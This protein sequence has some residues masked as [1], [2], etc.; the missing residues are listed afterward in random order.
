MSANKLQL[1]EEAERRGILP[2]EQKAMLDEARK[3]GLVQPLSAQPAGQRGGMVEQGTISREDYMRERGGV[4]FGGRPVPQDVGVSDPI[5]QPNRMTD[6]LQ[7]IAG[8]YRAPASGSLLGMT[9]QKP[10]FSAE[11]N[12]DAPQTVGVPEKMSRAQSA[13][14]GVNDFNPVRLATGDRGYEAALTQSVKDN[15]V[16]TRLGQAASLTAG[17]GAQLTNRAIIA[18]PRL[19]PSAIAGRT[20]GK[21]VAA[22]LTRYGGRLATLGALGAADYA[23]YNFAAEAP[24]QARESG[25]PMPTMGERANFAAEGL[26]DPYGYAPLPAMSMLYRA[27]RG[28]FTAGKNTTQATLAANKSAPKPEV[29]AAGVPG[30]PQVQWRG[31]SFTPTDVQTRVAMGGIDPKTNAS[32]REI[33]IDRLLK[34]G[35]DP[36]EAEKAVRILSYNGYSNV[37][38]MLFEIDNNL[39]ELA[40][41]VGRVNRP[42]QKVLRDEFQARR[43][44]MPDEI[45][46][47]L[48][49]AVG[50]S[51][52]DLETFASNMTK[53][54]EGASSSGYKAAYGVEVSD[55]AWQKILGLLRET[56]DG[57]DAARKGAVLARN[58]A[59]RDPAK[60]E[61]ARQLDELADV[62]GGG[63]LPNGK[64]STMALDF[65]D[66]GI[67]R[68][69]STATR[70]GDNAYSSSLLDFRGALRGSGL[71]AET[72]L[73]IPRTIYAQYK[74]AERAVEFGEK[75]FGKS[76]SLRDMKNQFSAAM[77]QADEAFE[78]GIGEGSGIIDQALMMGWVRGAENAVEMADNPQTLIRQLYGSERQRDKLLSMLRELPDEAPSG[79]KSDVT[80][81]KKALVGSKGVDQDYRFDFALSTGERVKGRTTMRNLFDRQKAMI[82]SER[83]T[84]GGSPT[85]G[86]ADAIANQG[87]DTR[88][89]LGVL[90]LLKAPQEIPWKAASA[91]I[92]RITQP[93]IYNPAISRELG[94]LLATRGKD[95][96]LAVIAEIRARQIATGK[97]PKPPSG[98]VPPSGPIRAGGFAGF[99]GKKPP[100]AEPLTNEQLFSEY[101]RL[102]PRIVQ[103]SKTL[104]GVDFDSVPGAREAL[105]ETIGK[106]GASG[107]RASDEQIIEETWNLMRRRMRHGPDWPP[108]KSSLQAVGPDEYVPDLAR[109]VSNKTFFEVDLDTAI[110][111]SLTDLDDILAMKGMRRDGDLI[112]LDQVKALMEDP[113]LRAL[114][115]GGTRPNSLSP[116]IRGDLSN[117]LAGA[118]L[119]GIAPADSAEE[120]ARNMAIGAGLGGG[121]R[122]VGKAFGSEADGA[123]RS[124]GARSAPPKTAAQAAKFETPGSPEWE[125]AKAKGLDMS[126]EGT[127]ARARQQGYNTD[128][129]LYHGTDR[130]GFE[131]FDVNAPARARSDGEQ[132]IF[133]TNNP[134]KASSF[135]GV[136]NQSIMPLYVRGKIKTVSADDLP[137]LAIPDGSGQM[138]YRSEAFSDILR[139]AKAEGFDG[140]RFRNVNEGAVGDQIAIFDP[141]NI[142]SVNAAFD[143]DKAASPILTA[144]FGSGR[145]VGKPKPMPMPPKRNKIGTHAADAAA[146]AAIGM[147]PSTAQADTGGVSAE[148]DAAK[149]RVTDIEAQIT[150]IEQQAIPEL[151][152]QIRQLQDPKGDIASKQEILKLRGRSLGTTG[153]RGDGVDGV[154]GRNTLAAINDEVKK[155]EADIRL[156][157][158]DKDDLAKELDKARKRRT[159]IEL[160]QVAEDGKV[161]PLT[162]SIREFAPWIGTGLGLAW[163]TRGRYGAVVK[164]RA[165]AQAAAQRAN[166]LVNT[167]PKVSRAQSGPNSLSERASNLNEFWRLGGAGE[168]V[169]FKKSKAGKWSQR[170]KPA[171]P[172]TLFPKEKIPYRAVDAAWVGGGLTEAGISHSFVNDYKA[173]VEKARADVERY[174]EA[175]DVANAKLATEELKKAENM[176]AI[177]MAARALGLA[178]A[179]GRLAA[180]GKMPYEQVRPHINMSAAEQEQAR[181]L[182]KMK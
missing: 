114:D 90:N 127:K 73:N 164:S 41:A 81:K 9:P 30:V 182:S 99:G 139:Q 39:A 92:E 122:R 136:K 115:T 7:G 19:V 3:R 105:V 47:A 83:M 120:R 110:R 111:E 56:P 67:G 55:D 88:R 123:V 43:E 140:V 16:T 116:A 78:D 166:S 157:R 27:G 158:Q 101:E 181:L 173:R 129:V 132:A 100:K 6:T 54:A 97:G 25:A 61:A 137:E 138:A 34:E 38:E 94:E 1:L 169:P 118:G 23:A 177:A 121:A 68:K 21:S 131:K 82:E 156:R 58:S 66:R 63:G 96:L 102:A 69:V 162:E 160:R 64:L 86:A 150:S 17:G 175:G 72:G 179:G 133:L 79:I 14:L 52:D 85:A 53:A 60:L 4:G 89:A 155:I 62:L 153:P 130:A 142:R 98:T 46:I 11:L 22:R 45:R 76:R 12:L 24:N 80:K 91:V 44:A 112:P 26:S 171:E 134:T 49:E 126:Q 35:F 36:D 148:L 29:M 109:M 113:R 168:N 37:D 159:D 135:A 57:V 170:P 10:D 28:A 161:G 65:L 42:G 119:G 74:A 84:V 143:P 50:A 117:A 48:R 176:L 180:G 5:P 2:P 87:G 154:E 144:G 40:T 70:A 124:A 13:A 141:S 174:F 128:E 31:G 104:L 146:I 151:E 145:K 172:S 59:R 93:M 33:A 147:P 167:S 163:M 71:D 15:P 20:A 95:R 51:G 77:R 149:Q 106:A 32:V 8:P 178:V 107:R 18:A 108:P 165:A 103:A 152:Q 125:A 75:A